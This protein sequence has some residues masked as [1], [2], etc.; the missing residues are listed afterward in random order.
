[1]SG[2]HAPP[3][4][5]VARA[6]REAWDRPT[7]VEPLPGTPYGLVIYG[8]PRV[9]SGPA[10]AS[11]VAGIA[12]LVVALVVGC[13]GLGA[14]ADGALAWVAGAFAVLA[15]FLGGAGLW[16]GMLALRQARRARF[17]ARPGGEVGG[18]GLAISGLV[19]GACALAITV[20]AMLTAVL[21][22]L[23]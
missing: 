16:L 12:G 11:L 17:Q 10:V 5:P 13:F 3:Q 4:P 1:M 2:Y 22:A 15:A 9:V 8:T 14:T 18:R 6:P 21:L 23:A 7:R 19:C 20:F